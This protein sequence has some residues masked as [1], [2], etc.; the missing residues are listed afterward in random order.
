MSH[1]LRYHSAMP[2]WMKVTSLKRGEHYRVVPECEGGG[3]AFTE[4][5]ARAIREALNHQIE[6]KDT[7]DR[8]SKPEEREYVTHYIMREFGLWMIWPSV[9]DSIPSEE[10]LDEAIRKVCSNLAIINRIAFFAFKTNKNR[11]FDIKYG[12]R[13]PLKE[14]LVGTKPTAV[15]TDGYEKEEEAVVMNKRCTCGRWPTGDCD[16]ACMSS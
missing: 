15:I 13:D 4:V 9:L 1:E 8:L 3:I 2:G 7:V 6:L 5:I 10:V 12:W 11:V 14:A 16:D